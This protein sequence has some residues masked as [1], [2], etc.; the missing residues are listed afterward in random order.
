MNNNNQNNCNN[1]SSIN[2]IETNELNKSSDIID[3]IEIN[4]T[5][6]I[7]EPNDS[8]NFVFN[9]EMIEKYYNDN[10]NIKPINNEIEHEHEY[11]K[12]TIEDIQEDIKNINNAINDDNID[13]DF[14]KNILEEST[15]KVEDNVDPWDTAIND[16]KFIIN[17]KIIRI[18][19]LLKNTNNYSK[20]KIDD[21]SLTYITI[22][23]IA[24]L[25]SKIISHHLIKYN[26][27][28][29]KIKI[30]DYTS[31]VGGNVLSFCKYFNHVYAIEISKLRYEY[32][33]NNIGVYNFKNITCI[34]DSAINFTE[35]NFNNNDIKVVFI[36]PPWGGSEYKNLDLLK[37]ELGNIPI[38]ELII[39]I[40]T[41]FANINK[42]EK[43]NKFI[44]LK[45]PRNYDIEH[46]YNHI[47]KNN[48]K[49]YTICSYLYILNKMLIVVCEFF[50]INSII[51]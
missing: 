19:P 39:D 45:L 41:R 49:D 6:E 21:D 38:E 13:L 7:N 35:N 50:N 17:N 43:N 33:V 31:G 5:I 48:I 4:E 26:I 24:D 25:T 22:R 16:N 3:P 30:A 18:F 27:N 40:F 42:N 8:S 11:L 1:Y 44:I 20:L 12:N 28:P 37:L 34:N 9:Q 15:E 47:K 23:E 51:H 10:M 2:T 46:L 14:N 32:L 29:Q 36:D